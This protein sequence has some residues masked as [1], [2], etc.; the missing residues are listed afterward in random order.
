MLGYTRSLPKYQER[1]SIIWN[2]PMYGLGA[3]DSQSYRLGIG[4]RITNS[5]MD[6]QKLAIRGDRKNGTTDWQLP[7]SGAIEIG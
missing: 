4:L 5:H 7:I 3:C 2:V 1:N 6:E